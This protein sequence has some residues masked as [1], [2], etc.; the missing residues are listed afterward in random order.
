MADSPQFLDSPIDAI[1]VTGDESD[2]PPTLQEK[3]HNSASDSL[4]S[5]G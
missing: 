1:G 3:F 4:A 5:A 2:T